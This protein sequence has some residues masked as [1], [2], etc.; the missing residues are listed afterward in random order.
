M[1]ERTQSVQNGGTYPQ[2]RTS[3]T[4]RLYS[5]RKQG[6]VLH[7]SHPHF[8]I[9]DIRDRGRERIR[10]IAHVSLLMPLMFFS[11]GKSYHSC[12]CSSVHPPSAFMG[13]S[14]PG[15]CERSAPPLRPCGS[16][17]PQKA[18]A[19]S[20]PRLRWPSARANSNV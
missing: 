12:V 4:L 13:S 17:R 9:R 8:Q 1:A 7:L 11:P 14:P 16:N 10:A 5:V 18:S 3:Q 6:T 2:C 15:S 19:S 20:R